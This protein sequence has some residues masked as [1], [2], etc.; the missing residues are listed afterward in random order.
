M[1]KDYYSVLGVSKDADG[2]TIKKAYRKLALKYHPD[3][4]KGDE[5]ASEKFKELNEA[6]AV[7][8]DKEKR[9]QYDTFGST[10]FHQRFSQEDIFK[11][12][13][14][15]DIFENLFGQGQRR[16]PSR[17]R[18]PF[19]DIGGFGGATSNV[20]NWDEIFQG[21]RS[22]QKQR[23]RDIS[24]KLT[25]TLEEAA[26]GEKKYIS[27]EYGSETK[28]VK[29]EIPKGIRTGQKLRVNGHGMTG[30]MGGPKGDLLLE[31]DIAPHR[32]FRRENDNLYVTKQISITQAVFGC[33]IS[34]PTLE[35]DKQLKIKPGVQGNTLMRLKGHGM[36]KMNSEV[37]GDLYVKIIVTTP[38][39]LNSEQIKLFKELEKSGI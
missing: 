9:S 26:K 38:T 13:N 5:A 17:S 7:L 15:N 34:V 16:R 1:G 37:K 11:G 36:S 3:K 23:G 4:N 18:N 20:P 10:E 33:L 21:S 14:V 29:I 25:I 22:H 2:N 8:S 6:Y 28:K 32:L 31:I 39:N 35:G 24:Y 30:S 27:L 19:E 12:F